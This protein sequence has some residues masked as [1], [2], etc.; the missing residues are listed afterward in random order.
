MDHRAPTAVVIGGSGGIG[1]ACGERL[2]ADGYAVTLVARN[3]GRLADAVRGIPGARIAVAD[4]GD[5]AAVRQV[6]A[7][8]DRVRLLLH[9]SGARV[10]APVAAQDVETFDDLYAGHLRSVFLCSREALARMGAGSRIVL[11]SS[12]AAR[13]PVAGLSG[14]CAM[15]AGLGMFARSLAMEVAERGIGV[16][17]L[18][19]G[20]VDTPMLVKRWHCLRPADVAEAVSYLATVDPALRIAEFDIRSVT[21]G[22]YAPPLSGPADGPIG[23][24]ARP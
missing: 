15:K 5:E 18:A 22:P 4:C 23:L 10:G 3:A 19:P 1:V 21:S 12:V 24:V 11:T 6:F 20:Q 2:A 17:L 7:G 14:Y 9:A 16:Y 8:I 13:R